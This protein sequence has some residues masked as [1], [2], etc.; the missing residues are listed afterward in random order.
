M[1]KT[2]AMFLAL[3][4]MTV[5][6]AGCTPAHTH[7]GGQWD[8][9]AG[10]HWKLCDCGEKLDAGSHE[11]DD[12]GI[13]AICGSQIWDHG[14]NVIVIDFDERGNFA[15]ITYYDKNGKMESED[16]RRNTYDE[17]GKLT[18]T[19]YYNAAGLYQEDFFSPDGEGNLVTVKSVS[20]TED[21]R[22]E[23][24]YDEN[25]SITSLRCYEG[26]ELTVQTLFTNEYCVDET[27]CPWLMRTVARHTH[28]G[29]VETTEYNA[30]GNMM[31]HCVEDSQG[32]VIEYRAWEFL[33]DQ[34]GYLEWECEY[35]AQGK[36]NEVHYAR[37]T[38]DDGSDW[39]YVHFYTEYFP[40]GSKTVTE[41]NEYEEPIQITIY[42]AAGK[43]VE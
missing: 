35:D 32:N 7:T 6:F 21:G 27:L 43:I 10:Q 19:K 22:T 28:T 5:L 8:R 11:M 34:E 1:R 40:D 9:D 25:G 33:Y 17:K 23:E 24:E 42:D 31:L 39:S 30:E 16:I 3:T 36:V 18:A 15:R 13:C 29:L 4:L 2:I 41:N 26:D 38:D 14:D 20:Y 12:E 37:A